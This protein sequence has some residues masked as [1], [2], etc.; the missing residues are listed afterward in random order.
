ML[1]PKFIRENPEIV[2]KNALAKHT[3]PDIDGY[4]SLDER[5]RRI[6]QEAQELKEKRN[7]VSEEI[8]RLKK[9]K[10]NADNLIAEM[11]TVSDTIKQLDEDLRG[12][13]DG[14]ENISLYIPNVLHSSVPEG[15]D[16]SANVEVRR[17]DGINPIGTE[18]GFRKDHATIAKQLGIVDFERGA[19]ISGSGFPLYTGKGARL[20]R[21]LLNFMLDHHTAQNGYTEVFVPFLV[22]A[23][24]MR[25]TGQLPKFAEDM[26]H[27]KDDDLFLIPTAEVPITNIY[28][29]DMLQ[30][31][32][33]TKKHCGYS[34]CFR[35][36]AGSYGKDTRGFLRLHQFNKV[37]LVKFA[38]PD[39]SYN[40]L[41][42]LVGDAEGV[43]KAL[44]IP[45]RTILLCNGDTGFSSAKTYDLE[46]W[47]PCEQK[48]LEV[49]SCSNFEDFQARRANIR[50]RPEPSAK[51]EFVHTLNGSGLATPRLMV[52][53]LEHYQ[54]EDGRIRIPEPLQQYCGFDII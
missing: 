34:A 18:A 47:S 53:L 24:S 37:E 51:P 52:A 31:S 35:R 2:R 6:I 4:L 28:R 30:A 5:R 3:Q 16:A 11:K 29:D 1:D 49:S 15:K 27:A 19:K 22:N 48:W 45:F 40:E 38:K 43:L 7:T 12:V 54:T 14:L 25:G 32:E 26:Y 50:F 44:G 9:A 13:E 10:E 23:T 17:A 42:S 39:E 41:E 20:E 33:L 21:A 46:V 36:E 8:A